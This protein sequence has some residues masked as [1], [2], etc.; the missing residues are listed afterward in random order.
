MAAVATGFKADP[1]LKAVLQW[2]PTIYWTPAG[3]I[4]M[5]LAAARV[6]RLVAS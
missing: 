4:L 6:K 2:V 1:A 5:H 3:A